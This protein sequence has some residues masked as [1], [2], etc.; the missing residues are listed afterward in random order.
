MTSIDTPA[1][2][3]GRHAMSLGQVDVPLRDY[4]L[5]L[6]ILCFPIRISFA[7][8]LSMSTSA[9]AAEPSASLP[10]PVL[11]VICDACRAQGNAGDGQ[12]AG[13]G[14]ILNFEPVP[15]RPQVGNWTPEQQRAFIVALAIT[16]SPKRAGI[17][18]GR[19][20]RGAM[21]LRSARGGE[22]FSKAWDAALAIFAGREQ[23]VERERTK[24]RLI[25]PVLTGGRELSE[26][27]ERELEEQRKQVEEVQARNRDR[28]LRARRLYLFAICGSEEKRAAWETL[29]G[30]VDWELAF[31]IEP[32]PN[33]P[34]PVRLVEPDMLLTA[35]GGC[36]PEMVGCG[37]DRGQEYM[38]A[39]K[40]ARETGEE[41]PAVRRF[42]DGATPPEE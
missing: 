18:I 36:L 11:P 28:F 24:G 38:A 2:V 23:A 33:E 39:C 5:A 14:D 20:D 30:P 13:V 35:E 9:S 17:A 40:E 19:D 34:Y 37:R 32:Q 29:C 41:G 10:T 22:S 16:G 1:A 4:R 42:F 21:K 27:D 3:V 15:R 26:E 12:F 31:K 7:P 6:G 8:D 25:N